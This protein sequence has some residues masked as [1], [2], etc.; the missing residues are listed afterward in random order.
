M[1]NQMCTWFALNRLTLNIS[2]TKYMLF[3]NMCGAKSWSNQPIFNTNYNLH[4]T[5]KLTL[6]VQSLLS[7]FEKGKGGTYKD[8][9]CHQIF[10]VYLLDGKEHSTQANELEWQCLF[11][12]AI[13]VSL[14]PLS[15]IIEISGRRDVNIDMFPTVNYWHLICCH[16]GSDI[17]FHKTF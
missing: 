6:Y 2:K 3:G 4:R 8:L 14:Y 16:L 7:L 9:V 12:H 15:A 11:R 5:E 10:S 17:L 13:H 1:L